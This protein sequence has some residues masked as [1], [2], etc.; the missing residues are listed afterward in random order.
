MWT[1]GA[2][3]GPKDQGKKRNA[4]GQLAQ[5]QAVL[6]VAC[7]LL[8]VLLCCVSLCLC[9]LVVVSIVFVCLCVL[10]VLVCCAFSYQL[11]ATLLFPTPPLPVTTNET[12]FTSV[13]RSDASSEGEE[14][15]F[16]EGEVSLFRAA[17]KSQ[18]RCSRCPHL[19]ALR[20][21]TRCS[22][23]TSAGVVGAYALDVLG[24]GIIE[25]LSTWPQELPTSLCW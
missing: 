21:R 6:F 9:V 25:T 15:R 13:K 8:C 22:G 23:A 12:L 24:L 1:C 16:S 5:V 19:P 3:E 10:C 11:S 20:S 17:L 2:G 4:T 14:C 18:R 7:F